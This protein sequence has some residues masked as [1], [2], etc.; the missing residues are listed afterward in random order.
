MSARGRDWIEFSLTPREWPRWARRAFVLALP[1]S[2]PAFVL[3]LCLLTVC[4]CVAMA[5]IEG[6]AA[7]RRLWGDD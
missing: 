1:I 4:A 3:Y 5:C 2:G 7:I 6:V